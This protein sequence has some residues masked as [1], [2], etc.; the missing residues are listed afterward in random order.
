MDR[1]RKELERN[2]SLHSKILTV[3]KAFVLC[4][5]RHFPQKVAEDVM[6]LLRS[7]FKVTEII[8][9]VMEGDFVGYTITTMI[10]GFGID[11]IKPRLEA[12]GRSFLGLGRLASGARRGG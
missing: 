7:K 10:W 2:M 12:K 3:G 11:F 5:A 8:P 4:K 1:W 6:S 9:T